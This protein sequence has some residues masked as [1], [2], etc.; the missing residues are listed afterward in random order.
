M[1]PVSQEKT[2]FATSFGL[3]EFKVMPFGLH[4]APTTFQKTI[5]HVLRGCQKYAQAYVDDIVVLSHS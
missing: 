5:N 4:T 3:Y 1:A 2:A